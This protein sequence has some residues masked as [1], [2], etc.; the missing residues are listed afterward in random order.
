MLF[1]MTKQNHTEPPGLFDD[2]PEARTPPRNLEAERAVLGSIL[3]NE[4]IL[5]IVIG[6]LDVE[7]FYL[8]RHQLIYEAM[9]EQLEVRKP[10]DTITIVRALGNKIEEV[11]GIAYV[12]ELADQIPAISNIRYYTEI[13]KSCSDLRTLI[14]L[15]K[16]TIDA[17]Y[18]NEDEPDKIL[19]QA[20]RDILTI[21]Q[22]RTK[23]LATAMQAAQS[24]QEWIYQRIRGEDKRITAP[25]ESMN[26]FIR[27]SGG[28]LISIGAR[29]S[30]GKTAFLYQL[31]HHNCMRERKRGALFTP[32]MTKEET[33][34][35][36]ISLVGGFSLQ[37]AIEYDNKQQLGVAAEI[38]ADLSN[39]PLHIEDSGDCNL[40]DLL[41]KT[42]WVYKTEGLDFAAFDY[43]NIM[44]GY[45]S[46]NYR[47]NRSGEIGD[48]TGG[49]KQL[50][51]DLKIPVI[52]LFQLNRDIEKRQDSEPRM[53]DAKDSGSIEQD[54]DIMGF[55]HRPTGA[56]GDPTPEGDVIFRKNR[57]G[58]RGRF[59]IRFEGESQRF[60]ERGV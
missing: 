27:M 4:Q 48:I 8:S 37:D 23:P 3:L 18:N 12:S 44:K 35:R 20:E 22:S 25:W 43:V 45:K 6:L 16:E 51:K 34:E 50:A 30:V 21:R 55:I 17:A 1:P 14:Q 33:F 36:L 39:M 38:L 7:D 41:A 59:A 13:V 24:T 49:L 32:E 31:I 2:I 47:G 58:R 40:T 60:Y 42:R 26:Q 29:P 15:S 28:K 46:R 57:Q 10:I 11:G 19:D 9:I 56:N 52:L 54:S 5:D 53:S